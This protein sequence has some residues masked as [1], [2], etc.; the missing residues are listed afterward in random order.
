[1][2]FPVALLENEL[3]LAKAMRYRGVAIE[4][5]PD[6]LARMRQYTRLF[7]PNLRAAEPGRHRGLCQAFA[8]FGLTRD[9]PSDLA[10]VVERTRPD[11][12]AAAPND[13]PDPPRG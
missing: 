10:A 6:A 2:S 13:F 9:A 4:F 5:I 3:Q 11:I 7:I 1:M 12:R 8:P